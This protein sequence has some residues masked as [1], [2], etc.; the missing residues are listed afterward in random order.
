MKQSLSGFISNVMSECEAEGREPTEWELRKMYDMAV[1]MEVNLTVKTR[2]LAHLAHWRVR[3]G[4]QTSVPH[5]FLAAFDAIMS[6]LESGG[7][8]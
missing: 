6:D 1:A 5:L 7:E 4:L 3:M 8:I 2:T